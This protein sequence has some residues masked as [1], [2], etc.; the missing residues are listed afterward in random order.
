MF[1]IG[2]R[3]GQLDVVGLQFPL[4]LANGEE[5][6]ELQY[7]K[8]SGAT[9]SQPGLHTPTKKAHTSFSLHLLHN[10]HFFKGVEQV[11]YGT[12]VV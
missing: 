11:L 8:T 12:S 10:V 7:R 4:A 9:T 3:N 6:H 2:T 1:W 5:I